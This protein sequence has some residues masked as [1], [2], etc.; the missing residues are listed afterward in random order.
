MASITDVVKEGLKYPLNDG[1]KVLT[2]GAIFLV[3]SIISLLMDYFVYDSLMVIEDAAPLET[4]QSLFA[5]IPQTNMALIAFTG[6]VTFI[7][8]LFCAGYIYEIIK[9]AIEGRNELPGFSDI[10]GLFLNGIRMIIVEIGYM[11]LPIILFFL[12]LMLAANEAV[13][14]GVNAIGGIILLIALIFAIFA[15]LCEVMAICHMVSKDEL[16]A[17]FRFKEILALIKNIGW[18]KFIGILL[19]SFIVIGILSVFF[20]VVFTGI[21]FGLSV[22]IG[23]SLAFLIIKTIL[24]SLLVTPYISIVIGRIYGSIYKEAAKGD[25]VDEN[26]VEAESPVSEDVADVESAVSEDVADEDVDDI[27]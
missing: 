13:G 2:F 3:S 25:S 23:S 19:F 6:I 7:I 18:G 27:K 21:A 22:I 1:K 12:G 20:D 17:A 5:A 4:F 15:A 8:M 14:S 11:I 26:V 9:Y 24:D 10:K 16:A